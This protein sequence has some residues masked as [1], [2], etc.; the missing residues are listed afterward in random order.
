MKTSYSHFGNLTNCAETH[1]SP[2][3]ISSSISFLIQTAV[4]QNHNYLDPGLRQQRSVRYHFSFHSLHFLTFPSGPLHYLSP[5]L[6]QRTCTLFLNSPTNCSITTP[7][8]LFS[9]RVSLHLHLAF[10]DSKISIIWVVNAVRFGRTL[11]RL[12]RV[13]LNIRPNVPDAHTA[14]VLSPGL[15]KT[16]TRISLIAPRLQE[17]EN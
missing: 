2:A 14:I 1:H 7:R 5:L 8:L 4:V 17:T 16:C 15:L 9:S 3:L 6:R 13:T 10:Q 12:M 11:T